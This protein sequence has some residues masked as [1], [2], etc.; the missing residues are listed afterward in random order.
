[1]ALMIRIQLERYDGEWDK[2]RDSQSRYPQLN[3]QLR[4]RFF[5]VFFSYER[6]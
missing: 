1:M 5:V 4:L 6:L 2:V 3:L